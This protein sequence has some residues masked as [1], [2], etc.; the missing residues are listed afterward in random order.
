MDDLNLL[1]NE[2]N[3]T[4]DEELDERLKKHILLNLWNTYLQKKEIIM[5]GDNLYLIEQKPDMYHIDIYSVKQ[6]I[7]NLKN[8]N[9]GIS[10]ED[11]NNIIKWS[12]YNTRKNLIN[13]GVDVDIHSLDGYC[14]LAQLISLY[15]LEQLGLTV[16]K[17]TV[18][19]SFDYPYN[20]AFGTVKFL[21]NEDDNP[22]EKYFLIDTTYRQFFIKEKCNK[23]QFYL[24]EM[25]GPDVGYYVEDKAFAQELMKSG[26][27]EL[28]EDTAKKYG[29]PFTKVFN[30]D[31]N[32]NYF[33]S[34]VN[35][36]NDYVLSEG[37]LEG[38]NVRLP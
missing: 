10:L 37:D 17:N 28:N 18:S 24:D 6:S 31:N 19:D 16:T 36:K 20:H 9:N 12:V 25:I 35:S 1:L 29:E 38:L 15:P 2:M 27:I 7:E 32:I 5:G 4:C 22:V 14:E 13:L 8:S 26:F 3:E 21:I 23:I 11:A 30:T 33:E 34:I